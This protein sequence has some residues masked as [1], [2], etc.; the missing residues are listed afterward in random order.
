MIPRMG[1]GKATV[2]RWVPRKRLQNLQV[3][4]SELEMI[5]ELHNLVPEVMAVT[6]LE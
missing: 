1:Q 5:W 4:S 6:E 2:L 3:E